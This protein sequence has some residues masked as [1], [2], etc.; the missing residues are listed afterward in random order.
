MGGMVFLDIRDR[1]GL[2]QVTC[3]PAH[4][5]EDVMKQATN[6]KSEYVVQVV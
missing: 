2:T 4:V 3:D 6:V 5:S 1:Y